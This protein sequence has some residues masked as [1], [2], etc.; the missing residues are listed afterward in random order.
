M[1]VYRLITPARPR[2]IVVVGDFSGLE[3]TATGSGNATTWSYGV[4]DPDHASRND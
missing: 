1:V 2:H 4:Y 3:D